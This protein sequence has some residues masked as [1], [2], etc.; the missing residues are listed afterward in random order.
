M[1]LSVVEPVEI[2]GIDT[3]LAQVYATIF[4]GL[5]A[6]AVAIVAAIIAYRN[7]FGWSPMVVGNRRGGIREFDY[8]FV[9]GGFEVWNRHK[10]PIVI[11]AVRVVFEETRLVKHGGIAFEERYWI[12]FC[13]DSADCQF[14]KQLEPNS[15]EGVSF[16]LYVQREGRR[17]RVALEWP[18]IEV[19]YLDPR[20]G[21]TLT[22]R[23][24]CDYRRRARET[25]Q[26][27]QDA[28]RIRRENKK[29]PPWLSG[30]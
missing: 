6:S 14:E 20:R 19:T 12:P 2:F 9:T 7:G 10:Y 28:A 15:R 21:K 22:A 16:K 3:R 24:R 11:R 27:W 30:N 5:G 26:S 13:E 18:S 25:I 8:E 17:A 29:P 23:S 4:A 1:G